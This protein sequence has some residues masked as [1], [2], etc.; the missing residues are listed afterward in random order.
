MSVSIEAPDT[1][2]RTSLALG[3]AFLFALIFWFG[4]VQPYREALGAIE[5][6]VT[7]ARSALAVEERLAARAR[8]VAAG[9]AAPQVDARRDSIATVAA[10]VGQATAALQAKISDIIED[11]GGVLTS[12]EPS[13]ASR[14]GNEI[15]SPVRLRI[16]M[17]GDIV[18]LQSVLYNAELGRPIMVIDNL[19]VRSRTPRSAS[20][21]H[22]LDIQFDAVGFWKPEPKAEAL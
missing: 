4:A 15:V 13:P 9:L 5:A 7:A 20:Q 12:V 8:E 6:R 22:P 3:L 10:S 18:S 17:T 19:F 1:P 11:A 2:R 14:F 16:A 21:A